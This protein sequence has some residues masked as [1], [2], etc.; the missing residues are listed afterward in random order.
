MKTDRNG[1]ISLST[2][3]TKNKSAPSDINAAVRKELGLLGSPRN[4]MIRQ[5]H[6]SNESVMY[7]A[8]VHPMNVSVDGYSRDAEMANGT[9]SNSVFYFI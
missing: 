6:R 2:N 9:L 8:P 3:K 5:I 4:R 7:R 1:K